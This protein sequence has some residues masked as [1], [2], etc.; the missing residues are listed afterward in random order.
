MSFS[1]DLFTRL[2]NHRV[3]DD[4]ARREDYL[5]ECFAWVLANDSDLLAAILAPTGPVIQGREH[6]APLSCTDLEVATQEQISASDR[7]DLV[8]RGDGFLLLVECKVDAPYDRG[9]VERYLTHVEG[10]ERGGVVAVVPRRSVP[11]VGDTPTGD[12][13]LGVITWEHLASLLRA[14]DPVGDTRDGFRAALLALLESYGLVPFD[15]I[16]APWE[17]PDGVQD[18]QLIRRVC[19][20]LDAAATEVGADA[21]FLGRAPDPYRAGIVTTYAVPAGSGT[22]PRP[23]LQH[24]TALRSFIEPDSKYR[25]FAFLD[26]VVAVNFQSATSYG[27]SPGRVVE[28]LVDTRPVPR[29]DGSVQWLDTDEDLVRTLLSAGPWKLPEGVP[30]RWASQGV[31]E[32][33]EGYEAVVRR[34]SVNLVEADHLDARVEPYGD[35][36]VRI[37]IARTEDFIVAGEELEELRARYARLLRQVFGALFGAEAGRPLGRLLTVAFCDRS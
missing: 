14:L 33:R 6:V 21:E 29:V 16:V 37:V 34:I 4:R 35:W 12:R 15:G 13:F 8:V 28:F 31:R 5:T 19:A 17:G 26:A 24:F 9:Q 22:S 36:G 32:L 23:V 1:D 30:L 3:S 27:Y 7:P 2:I 20:V 18:A 10:V 25:Y 11:S